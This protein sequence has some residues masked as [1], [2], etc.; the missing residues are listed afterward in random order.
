MTQMYVCKKKKKCNVNVKKCKMYVTYIVLSI[1][2]GEPSLSTQYRTIT[3]E[4][5]RSPL[6]LSLVMA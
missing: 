3:M 4:T 2:T 6:F 1:S 5:L